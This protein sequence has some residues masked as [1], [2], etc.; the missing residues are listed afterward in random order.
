MKV[1][2]GDKV[3]DVVSSYQGIVIGITRWLNGC[4]RLGIQAPKKKDGTVPDVYW[5]DEPQVIV[6]KKKAVQLNIKDTGGPIPTPIRSQDP[7]HA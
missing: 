4:S 7:S 2:L 1:E 6:V 3:K 5:I